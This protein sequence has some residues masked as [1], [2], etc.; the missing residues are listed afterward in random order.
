MSAEP[1]QPLFRALQAR[2]SAGSLHDRQRNHRN[3]N[4]IP[5]RA[6][7]AEE[8]PAPSRRAPGRLVARLDP[9]LPLVLRMAPGPAA[10]RCRFYPARG[11]R[12]GPLVVVG[13]CEDQAGAPLGSPLCMPFGT[14]PMRLSDP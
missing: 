9:Q 1:P 10:P 6:E 13:T 8:A 14:R 5:P 3:P 11:A 12:S 4:A 2:R 7:S